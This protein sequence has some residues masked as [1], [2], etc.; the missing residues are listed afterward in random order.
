M[1]N[2]LYI[3]FSSGSTGVPKGIAAT[4]EQIW[5]N[6]LAATQALQLGYDDIH[7]CA[8]PSYLH[9]HE[10]FVRALWTGAEAVLIPES[11]GHKAVLELL[12]DSHVT[13][14]HAS[15]SYYRQLVTIAG[16][17]TSRQL[18]QL[19]TAE[20]G[21]MKTSVALQRDFELRFGV[22]L[23]PVWGSTEA[24]GIAIGG[25]EPRVGEGCVGVARPHYEVEVRS[26]DERPVAP[27]D[28]GQL[29]IRGMGVGT[30]MSTRP[31]SGESS[32]GIREVHTGDLAYKDAGG[33]VYIRGRIDELVKVHGLNVWLPDIDCALM[34]SPGV[35]DCV[36]VAIDD[37]D[38]GARIRSLVVLSPGASVGES[39]L[40]RH[41]RTLLEAHAVPRE[42]L[43]VNRAPRTPTGKAIRRVPKGY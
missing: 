33:R 6:T 2:V 29:I 40:L 27:G 11:T 28:V 20:S 1:S 3:N 22:R 39:E 38:R 9:T 24:T 8:F 37:E 32:H 14:I 10:L 26:E 23:S 4:Q 15:P 19:R 5:Y 35:E 25:T 12:S 13:R 34:S 41:C 17:M 36:S 31:K 30:E 7:F 16:N 42:I 18:A 21:G 43:F